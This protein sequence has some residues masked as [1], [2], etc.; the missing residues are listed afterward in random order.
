MRPP[1]VLILSADIY[2]SRLLF[3]YLEDAGYQPQL[4]DQGRNPLE[5]I[6][7]E[8]PD[9]VL[10]DWGLPDLTALA[11]LRSLRAAQQTAN[12][13]VVILMGQESYSG[14]GTGEEE[15]LTALEAG[16]D[17]CLTKPIQPRVFIAQLHSLLRRSPS[18]PLRQRSAPRCL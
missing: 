11:T 14:S 5:T 17:L 7:K 16:A 10:L 6:H 2:Q 9:L 13:P 3:D 18:A 8:K 15:R 4:A 1:T 12:L